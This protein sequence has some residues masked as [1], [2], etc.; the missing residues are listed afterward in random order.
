MERIHQDEELGDILIRSGAR[1]KNYRLVVRKGEV[2]AT[3]PLKGD[4][5]VIVDLIDK[6][7][8]E[9]IRQLGKQ[10]SRHL[11]FDDTTDLRFT[12]FRLRVVCMDMPRFQVLRSN[13]LFTFACPLDMPFDDEQIQ[14]ELHNLLN[15]I[16]RSE[17]KRLLPERVKE[18]AV[19][20][21]FSYSKVKIS[22]SQGRWG[23][24][25]STGNI[26]L[27][28]HLMK[29]PWRL[30][31]YVILHEL[32]HTVEMNHSDRFWR[33]MDRVTDG[34]AQT[35]RGELRRYRIE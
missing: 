28:L 1:Y 32:C 21:G 8:A 20:H 30:I 27:S 34:E 6:H 25:T 4:P 15:H 9:L 23:S 31:D 19:Q 12:S 26:N 16:L 13:D 10:K 35:L 14:H 24:C 5:R 17:A 11:T 22:S 2:S 33:L 18:L 3:M 29:L 7:R